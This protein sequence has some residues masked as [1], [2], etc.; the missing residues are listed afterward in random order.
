M[1]NLEDI[2]LVYY[3][4]GAYGP[5]IR[6]LTNSKQILIK[7]RDTITELRNGIIDEFKF[8]NFEGIK[9]IDIEE[10]II[11]LV[12][13][14]LFINAGIREIQSSQAGPMFFWQQTVNEWWNI[15]GLIEGLIEGGPAHQYLA[16]NKTLVEL[17]WEENLVQELNQ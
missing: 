14:S 11:K 7:I 6:I 10:I 15:E 17:V 16:N 12:T 2:F 9:M 3:Y 1:K 13:R 8:G 4:K 5:T